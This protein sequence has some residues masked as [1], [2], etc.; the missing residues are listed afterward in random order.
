MAR[1]IRAGDPEAKI[2]PNTTGAA[3][4]GHTY[5]DWLRKFLSDPEANREMD[6]FS[7]HY[8]CDIPAIRN[9]LAEKG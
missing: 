1:A 8:R 6:F 7:S 3:P 5:R 9:V 4:D 2:G